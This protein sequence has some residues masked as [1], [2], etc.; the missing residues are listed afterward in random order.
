MPTKMQIEPLLAKLQA[1]QLV[2]AINHGEYVF[3]HTLTQETVYQSLLRSTRRAIHA[4]V[5]QTY[6]ELYA[7]RLDEFAAELAQHYA[8]AGDSGKTFAYSMRAGDAAARVYAYPEAVMHYTRALELAR[9]S[10]LTSPS[11]LQEVYLKRGRMFEH[12]GQSENAIA[13][14]KELEDLARVRHHPT[15]ELAGLIA[16]TI[17][18][19]TPTRN[20]DLELAHHLA[21]RALTLARE[22]N[23]ASAEAKVLWTLMVAHYFQSQYAE[24]LQYGEASLAIARRLNLREQIAFTLNDLARAYFGVG[25]T[26]EGK[27][28]ITEARELWRAMDNL[29]MLADNLATTAE[30]LFFLGDTNGAMHYAREAHAVSQSIGNL[31]N[32]AYS[33]W[34]IGYVS[35]EIGDIA[36]GVQA[37]QTAVTIAKPASFTIALVIGNGMLAWV[38]GY[39]GQPQRGID[40]LN[41]V[42]SDAAKIHPALGTW[43]TALAAMLQ[44]W[45]GN[46][47]SAQAIFD[48]TNDLPE[49]NDLIF[50]SPVF[51]GLAKGEYALRQHDY[52]RAITIADHLLDQMQHA[53][54]RPFQ[55]DVL[56]IKGQ[57]LIK[58]GQF[59]SARALLLQAHKQ[60]QA[61]NARRP[62]WSI[63]KCLGQIEMLNGNPIPAQ[64]YQTQARNIIT[65]IAEHAPADLRASFLNLPAVCEVLSK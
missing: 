17:V 38:Y 54:I 36:A 20:Q 2:R 34:T 35:L 14:Y 41:Q 16:R 44:I 52:A 61:M 27:A 45:C 55:C 29:P 40:F 25:R 47:P 56:E 1:E 65:Y 26:D 39:M 64:A 46:L 4:R 37:L 53:G 22:L 42:D 8:Q 62:L 23:D 5:A 11:T 10:T 13:N 57:A 58:Q 24:A 7:N 9:T 21:E 15:L 63:L 59:D 19:A 50:F 33:L 51:L 43:Q 28:V 32:Q 3:K 30:G 60:A 18:H 6:E 12:A 31:W 48:R 49:F